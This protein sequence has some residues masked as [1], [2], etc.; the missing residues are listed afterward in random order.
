MVLTFH[1]PSNLLAARVESK[2]KASERLTMWKTSGRQVEGTFEVFPF[3]T[4]LKVEGLML[5]ED[6]WKASEG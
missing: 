5:E 4:R 1:L 2:R 3:E 6:K